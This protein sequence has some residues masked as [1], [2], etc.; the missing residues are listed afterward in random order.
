MIGALLLTLNNIIVM[1]ILEHPALGIHLGE[2]LALIE[3]D[4]LWSS[5]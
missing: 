4:I 2:R 5:L 1:G 3:E